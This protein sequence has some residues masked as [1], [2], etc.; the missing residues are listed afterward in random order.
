MTQRMTLL[1]VT[2]VKLVTLVALVAL[3]FSTASPAL[4]HPGH[5][6]KMLGTVTMVAADH[7]ML[8][9]KDG[10]EATVYVNKDTKVLREKK[11][12]KL[13]DIQNGMRVVIT[14]QM[15]SDKMFAK[16]IELGPKRA[17]TK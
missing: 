15:E 2:F 13:E 1:P 12:A 10:K 4:A 3:T 11:P 16:T 9:D 5:A 6:H 8:K 14:A 7:V 17:G